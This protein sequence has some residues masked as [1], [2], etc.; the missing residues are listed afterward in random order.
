MLDV[1]ARINQGGWGIALVVDEHGRLLDTVTDGD[2]RRA[3]LA[4]TD[5]ELPVSTL[6]AR[7]QQPPVSAP[8]GT[9]RADLL[10]RMKQHRIRH[11]P[12]LDAAGRVAD[13][14]LMDDLAGTESFDLQAVVMAGGFG[15]RMLPLTAQTPKPMLP[16]DERPLVERTVEQLRAAGIKRVYMTTHYQAESITR[17]F[18]DGRDFGVDIDY[19]SEDVPLGTAGAL[20]RLNDTQEPLLVINGDIVTDLNFR[21]LL[22][23][24][25]EHQAEMTVGVRHYEFSVPYGVVATEDEK[26]TA[27]AEKPTHRMFVNAGIYLLEPHVCK[28]VPEGR[29]SDMTDL[30]ARMLAESRRVL[31]FPI[32]EYWVDVGR[33]D[34]YAKAQA[35][36][37]AEGAAR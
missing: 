7:R 6:K 18:G 32:S 20:A 29:R 5:L 34:D 14:A 1:M 24:H 13:L 4:G 15:S 36:A 21:S 27:I 31:A 37:A 26:I 10:R 30:I 28:L 12:L 35:R 22:A 17:H 23:F 16:I 3:I 2:L 33:P 9:P 19:V 11:L 8:V 25:R